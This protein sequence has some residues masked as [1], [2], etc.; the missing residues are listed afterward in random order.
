MNVSARASHT[1]SIEVDPLNESL[2]LNVSAG[3]S[4]SLFASFVF[5]S[6]AVLFEHALSPKTINTVNRTVNNF[7]IILLKPPGL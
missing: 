5:S 3:V 4:A 6:F 7:F 2:P 1:F